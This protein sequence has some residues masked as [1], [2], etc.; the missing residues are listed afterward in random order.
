LTRDGVIVVVLVAFNPFLPD[1]WS[2]LLD[3]FAKKG[4]EVHVVRVAAAD[5]R[6][7]PLGDP[8]VVGEVDGLFD[9]GPR[10]ES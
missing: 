2:F 6:L 9:V 8:T 1:L 7:P 3:P 5:P 4:A 10:V